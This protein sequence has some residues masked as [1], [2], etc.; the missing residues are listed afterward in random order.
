M[1]VWAGGGLGEGG[2][3]HIKLQDYVWWWW[4]GGWGGLHCLDI[5]TV[6]VQSQHEIFQVWL[7]SPLD[8]LG[9]NCGRMVLL[10][11]VKHL[12]ASLSC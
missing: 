10:V 1:G 7:V 5:K 2:F 3:V 6:E 9:N 4:G 8:Q 12:G 11:N